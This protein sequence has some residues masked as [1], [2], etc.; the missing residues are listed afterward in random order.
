[1]V[2]ALV[3]ECCVCDG[4]SGWCCLGGCFV[5]VASQNEGREVACDCRDAGSCV[6]RI[7]RVTGELMVVNEVRVKRGSLD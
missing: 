3:G 4:G 1:M 5:V 6:P 7:G 2:R